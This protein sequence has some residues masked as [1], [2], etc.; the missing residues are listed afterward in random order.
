MSTALAVALV[1]LFVVLLGLAF[2]ARLVFDPRI[3]K[4][5]YR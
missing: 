2:I 4:D 5:G 3:W 1:C